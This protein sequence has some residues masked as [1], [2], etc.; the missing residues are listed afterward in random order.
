M[1]AESFLAIVAQ[2]LTAF[3]A[4][5]LGSGGGDAGDVGSIFAAI[6]RAVL[7]W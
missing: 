7:G 5:V 2:V 6:L 3:L 1:L 4:E